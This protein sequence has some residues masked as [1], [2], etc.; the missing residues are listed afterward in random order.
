MDSN[1]DGLNRRKYI[2]ILGLSSVGAIAGCSEESAPDVEE[3]NQDP[4]TTGD[5]NEADTDNDQS[6]DETEDGSNDSDNDE[7]TDSEE[8][9]DVGQEEMVFSFGESAQFSTEEQELLFRPYNPQL[10]NVLLEPTSGSI[11]STV[12]ERDLFL[13]FNVDLENTGDEMA[14]APGTAELVV[15]KT[16]Y[17]LQFTYTGE[18]SYEPYE[19]LRS[20]VSATRKMTFSLPDTTQEGS[21][22]VDFG[23]LETVTAEWTLDL[24]SAT[25]NIVDYSGNSIGESITVS[26]GDLSY[27]LAVTDLELADSYTYDASYGQ[28]RETA[29]SGSQWA[30]VTVR[31]ENT[32]DQSVRVPGQFDT[33]AIAGNQQ[34]E[35]E[36]YLGDDEYSGGSLSTGV[37][38]E[39]RLIFEIPE[40]ASDPRIEMN[41]TTD[42]TATWQ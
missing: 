2:T 16:S 31:A 35:P 38:D 18:D 24:G 14:E 34:S 7:E 17:D 11:Y 13:S 29:G 15:G 12:P 30:I 22:F 19:E 32:G 33:R 10:T 8:E 26:A 20:G 42:L 28:Q 36:I 23:T 5:E 40:T 4:E 25:R 37:V 6:T 27:E 1:S 39:G 41:I 9:D 3:S 21:L